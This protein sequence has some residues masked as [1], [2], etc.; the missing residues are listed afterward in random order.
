MARQCAGELEKTKR[1]RLIFWSYV[2]DTAGTITSEHGVGIE[3]IQPNVQPI[4]GR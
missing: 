1:L 3:K 4:F 2:S